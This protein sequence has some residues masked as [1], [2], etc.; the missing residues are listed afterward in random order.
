MKTH[1]IILGATYRDT[2]HNTQGVCT[3]KCQYLTGCDRAVL[4]YVKDGET[5]ELWLD[6]NRLELVPAIPAYMLPIPVTTDAAK[7]GGPHSKP[8]GPSRPQTR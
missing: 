3:A 8:S 7:P 2:L 4:E 6:V 1:E 5:K